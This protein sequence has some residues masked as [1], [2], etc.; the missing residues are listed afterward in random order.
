MNK[1]RDAIADCDS[2][3][4]INQNYTKALLL[5]GKCYGEFRMYDAAATNYKQALELDKN[6]V[7]II[8]AFEDAMN[9]FARMKKDYYFVLNIDHDATADEIVQRA[10]QLSFI[11][12]DRHS[13]ASDEVKKQHENIAKLVNGA[14]VN[15]LATLDQDRQWK[16][17]DEDETT[18]H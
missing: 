13:R 11:H 4:Q 10:K 15:I 14:K 1:I 7:D 18:M 9:C 2:A 17:A 5:R 6:N 3:L 16:P 12:P 8:N